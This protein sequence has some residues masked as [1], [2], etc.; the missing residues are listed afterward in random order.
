VLA[1]PPVPDTEQPV[2]PRA[3]RP[4]RRPRAGR[5]G[6]W[7]VTGITALFLLVPVAVVVV[8]SFNSQQSLTAFGHPSLRWYT[9]LFQ[10]SSLLASVRVS[11]EVA[12]MTT[13]VATVVGTLLA[14]GLTR[15]RTGWSRP[16]NGILLLT[17]VT[18][19]IATAMSLFLIYTTQ[20]HVTLSVFTI[21]ASHI[22][23]SLVYVTVIVRTQISGL[24]REIEEAARDL[25]CGEM[26]TLR[27]VVLPQ[28]RSAVI[29]AA[30]LV[31]VLSFDD[32]VTSYLTTGVGTPPLPVYIYS[33]IKFGISPEINA[34]GT[35]MVAVS[36]VFGITGIFL[37]GFRARRGRA[38]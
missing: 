27:L 38:A 7:A 34:I 24:R 15:S 30:L 11:L 32:F 25:G 13:V 10:N 3:A 33:M 28:I 29:G 37:L 31:F 18:P 16:T 14:F 8:Y 9:A 26:Q 5:A 4:R 17:L 35:L 22:T 1:S 21:T 19:E 23:F 12:V 36:A 6:L 20:L 2:S